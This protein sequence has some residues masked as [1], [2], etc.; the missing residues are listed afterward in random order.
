[1][2]IENFKLIFNI[3]QMNFYQL[4]IRIE[5]HCNFFALSDWRRRSDHI[6]AEHR[7]YSIMLADYGI[8]VRAKQN[9]GDIYFAEDL[10]GWKRPI[11]H[12]PNVRTFFARCDNFGKYLVFCSIVYSYHCINFSNEF[13]GKMVIH[14]AKEPSVRLLKH[15]VRC[16]L[17][18]S[19]NQRFVLCS[20]STHFSVAAF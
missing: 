9:R 15:V 17:R 6:F 16:Y 2:L 4:A 20:K 1:M 3:L 18:L 5:N 8:R 14:L 11:I 19:D 13:Q 12:L 7:N 10:V